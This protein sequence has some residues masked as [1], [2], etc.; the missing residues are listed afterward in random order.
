MKIAIVC[1]NL[2]WQAGGTR[3]IY[4]L[5][6]GLGA[7]KHK[8]VIYAPE[9]NEKAFPELRADLD[10]RIVSPPYDFLWNKKI[11]GFL[12]KIIAKMREDRL[13]TL[14]ARKI[15][16]AMDADFDIVNVHD[17]AYKVAPFYKSRNPKTKI[18]W[19]ENDPPYVYLPKPN[20][21][22]DLLSRAYN[23]MRDIFA[24]SYFKSI[25]KVAVLDFYNR[26]WCKARGLESVVVRSGVDFNSFYRPAH[27]RTGSEKKFRLFSLGALN[28]YR[29]FED[30]IRASKILHDRG[31]AI[32]T[33]I[34]CKDI[35]NESGYR[36]KLKLLANEL[37]VSEYVKIN[38]DGV[39]DKGLRDE[40][41]SADVFVLTTYLPHPRNGY[42][43]G[44]TNFEA[45]AAGLPLLLYRT[46]TASEVLED[47]KNVLLVDAKNFE[48]I[49]DKVEFLMHDQN[50]YN[51][52][53]ADG[54]RFVK[55]NLS[56]D[57]YAKDLVAM[58]N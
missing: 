35:W 6:R 11:N 9:V 41:T 20:P 57:K 8:V 42:G 1:F 2:K 26:D 56:W 47:G 45:M 14:V 19:T 22:Y 5:A 23:K 49:A 24:R 58:F 16:D 17:F 32:E 52:I 3:L 36:H 12:Q 31:L 50:A 37:G 33:S 10:I 48:Q 29:R 55:E 43:W 46:S 54:Q 27:V 53:A 34:V 38:F 4:S 39:S 15:A 18:L 44:L 13:H 21:V 51:R 7:Q 40:F 28:P 25:D 30:L